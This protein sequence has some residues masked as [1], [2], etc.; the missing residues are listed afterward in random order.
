MERKEEE[1][2][3]GDER[4]GKGERTVGCHFKVMFP[5]TVYCLSLHFRAARLEST[6]QTLPWWLHC[7][8]YIIIKEKHPNS[9]VYSKAQVYSKQLLTD[10]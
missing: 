5:G 6:L 4:R 9:R 7:N 2:S 10:C 1:R 8:K 3:W